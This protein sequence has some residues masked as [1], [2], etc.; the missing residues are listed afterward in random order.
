MRR[1]HRW[2]AFYNK[3]SDPTSFRVSQGNT[4]FEINLQEE[5]KKKYT[6]QII[7][8]V[9]R[10]FFFSTAQGTQAQMLAINT[11]F[12]TQNHVKQVVAEKE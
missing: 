12:F 8:N 10:F 2:I 11:S 1:C 6:L 9:L 4:S 3:Q 5:E 7:M